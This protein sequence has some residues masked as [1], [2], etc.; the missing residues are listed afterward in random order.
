VTRVTITIE[1]IEQ[2]IQELA[3]GLVIYQKGG[4]LAR[5]DAGCAQLKALAKLAGYVLEGSGINESAQGEL[6]KPARYIHAGLDGLDRPLSVE[7][8]KH[9]E[10]AVNQ[11]VGIYHN[12]Q[13]AV[14]MQLLVNQG[15]SQKCAAKIA[16]K[17]FGLEDTVVNNLRDE[18]RK[19]GPKKYQAF[20]TSTVFP[21]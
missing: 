9:L 12:A 1:D 11:I 17:Q 13:A 20:R 2:F 21:K 16:G 7:V 15:K 3:Q 14:G 19:K 18:A 4:P 10:N 6:L 8:S 5:K